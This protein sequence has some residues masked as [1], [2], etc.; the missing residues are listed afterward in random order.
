MVGLRMDEGILFGAQTER[1]GDA[2]PVR[3]CLAADTHRLLSFVQL[4]PWRAADL[5]P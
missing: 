1:Q 2:G 5:N 3:F 4:T